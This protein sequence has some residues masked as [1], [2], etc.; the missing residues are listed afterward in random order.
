V[1]TGAVHG[2]GRLAVP[3]ADPRRHVA[4]RTELEEAR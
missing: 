4:S 1:V 2:N 3:L